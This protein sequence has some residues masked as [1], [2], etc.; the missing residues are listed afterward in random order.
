[1]NHVLLGSGLPWVTVRS[2]ERVPFFRS[3]ERAQ[4][5]GETAPFA[6]F[7]WHLIQQAGKELRRERGGRRAARSRSA[8]ET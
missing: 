2:D 3:I 5:D 8:R 7:L 1:M 4:V 6:R